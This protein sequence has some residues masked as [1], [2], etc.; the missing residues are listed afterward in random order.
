MRQAQDQAD[1]LALFFV[2]LIG[3]VALVQAF[4]VVTE[5]HDQ[6]RQKIKRLEYS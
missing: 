3:I 5:R 4:S 2:L 1:C 6:Q